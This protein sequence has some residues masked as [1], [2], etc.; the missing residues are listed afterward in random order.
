[1]VLAA[2]EDE[3]KPRSTARCKIGR[4]RSKSNV[5]PGRAHAPFS[6]TK[7][8][9]RES[10]ASPLCLG[11]LASVWVVAV[12]EDMS[13]RATNSVFALPRN[14]LEADMLKLARA[15]TEQ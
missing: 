9:R 11:G 5:Q 12:A 13:S 1:M 15:I 6:A 2:C 10:S 8:P 3:T 14:P 4:I 7:W